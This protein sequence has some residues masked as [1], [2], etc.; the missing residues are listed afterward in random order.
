MSFH[1]IG[2]LEKFEVVCWKYVAFEVR[3]KKD[4]T[5]YEYK[6]YLSTVAKMFQQEISHF[7]EMSSCL[8][9]FLCFKFLS[10]RFRQKIYFVSVY[11]CMKTIKTKR[12]M[13]RTSLTFW[14]LNNLLYFEFETCVKKRQRSQLPRR[15]KLLYNF[16][17]RKRIHFPVK[18]DSA[19]SF[20]PEQFP[21]GYRL[22]GQ[23]SDIV[24]RIP[25]RK[26]GSIS[27]LYPFNNANSMEF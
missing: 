15:R 8:S 1:S 23:N 17:S 7:K 4:V 13:I 27:F 6:K 16:S 5:S 25:L 19:P 9:K 21:S 24:F 22:S 20:H 2:L 14:F 12:I 18:I 10:P 26:Q 11:L 3:E